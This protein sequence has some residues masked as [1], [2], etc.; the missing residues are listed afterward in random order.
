MSNNEIGCS[1]AYR[2]PKTRYFKRPLHIYTT[3]FI[4]VFIYCWQR[5]PM[6]TTF[7][8]TAYTIIS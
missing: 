3:I 6:H 2:N 7:T 5:V 1:S 4:I 8:F